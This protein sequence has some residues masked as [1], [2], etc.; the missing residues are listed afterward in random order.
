MELYDEDVEYATGYARPADVPMN[1]WW[2]TSRGHVAAEFQTST[3][4][5]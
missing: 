2:A 3:Q 1:C 5:Y 4:T